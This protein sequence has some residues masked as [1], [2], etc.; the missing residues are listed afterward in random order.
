M[1]R[2]YERASEICSGI[3]LNANPVEEDLQSCLPRLR[4]MFPD[5]D[6]DV[7]LL[8]EGFPF[9]ILRVRILHEKGKIK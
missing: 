2:S 1:N 5:F 8:L 7:V 9:W 3:N 6:W 4:A